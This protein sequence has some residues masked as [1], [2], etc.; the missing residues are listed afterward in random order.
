MVSV[1]TDKYIFK[2]PGRPRFNTNIRMECVASIGVVDYVIESDSE[3]PE[4]IIKSLKPSFYVKGKD[5]NNLKYY[6]KKNIF[7]EKKNC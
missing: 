4:K 3:T 5:Y 7:L 1:T 2:G 6:I